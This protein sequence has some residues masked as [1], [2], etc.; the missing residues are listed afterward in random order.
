MS[1]TRVVVHEDL[2]AEDA[3]RA[4][5]TLLALGLDAE[6]VRQPEAPLLH[7]VSVAEDEVATALPA[8]ADTFREADEAAEEPPPPP[9]LFVDTEIWTLRNASASLAIA[10]LCLAIH[11][12]VHAGGGEVP[13]SRMVAAGAAAP[14]MIA[15]GQWW[16]LLTAV[17]LHFDAKHI[18]GNMSALLFLGPPLAQQIG[19]LRMVLLFVATGVA[20]NIAS[21][22]FG[23][24]AALKAGASGGICGLLG[25]LAGVALVAMSAASDAR[26][27]RP[28][29]QTLGALVALFGMIVGFEPGRDHYAHLGG[30]AAGVLLGRF[31]ASGSGEVAA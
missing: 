2:T 31:F 21:Q 4:V 13:R 23:S 26:Q 5:L 16:R 25:A 18:V 15:D 10:A 20:G 29:W 11:L 7:A 27:R 28:A 12:A 24:E 1:K 9:R 14:W 6:A 19:Q 22:L 30:V 8:L 17:F 3:R